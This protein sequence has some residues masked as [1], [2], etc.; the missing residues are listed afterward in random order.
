MLDEYDDEKDA[1]CICVDGNS[2]D[3]EEIVKK[4]IVEATGYS[5]IPMVFQSVYPS[6][7]EAALRIYPGRS[8]IVG[9]E[10]ITEEIEQIAV[11]YGAMIL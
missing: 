2:K 5:P 3:R 9:C 8:A 4:V 1:V 6:V 7:L 11:K 10:S